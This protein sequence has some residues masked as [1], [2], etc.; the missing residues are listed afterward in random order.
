M[1]AC[2]AVM[3]ALVAFLG[4]LKAVE[5]PKGAPWPPRDPREWGRCTW[6]GVARRAGV[7]ALGKPRSARW[8][9]AR[10]RTLK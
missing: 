1:K 7:P 10:W 4:V 8:A 9:H 2:W 6:L 5:S 3:A